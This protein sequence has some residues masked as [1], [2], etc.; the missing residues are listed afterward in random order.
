MPW[1]APFIIRIC[2]YTSRLVTLSF[3]YYLHKLAKSHLKSTRRPHSARGWD[4]STLG[5]PLHPSAAYRRGTRMEVATGITSLDSCTVYIVFVFSLDY[6]W[7]LHDTMSYYYSLHSFI[8]SN[9]F[10]SASSSPLLL[11]SAPDTARI[12]CRNFTPKRLRQLRVKDYMAARA[13]LEPTTL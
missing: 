9:H 11:R 4:N 7:V 1:M 8:H 2:S 6:A 13:C 10:Y 5:S 3:T 12:L